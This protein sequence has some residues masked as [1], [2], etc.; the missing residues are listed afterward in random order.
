MKVV[1]IFGA[2]AVGKKT[3]A[4]YLCA[5]TGFRFYEHPIRYDVLKTLFWKNADAIDRRLKETV[6]QALC[7]QEER[8]IVIPLLWCF[9][10]PNGGKAV[11]YF[12]TFF[13][14]AG[15]EVC[16]A[17]LTAD[18]DTLLQRNR[19]KL[20]QEMQDDSIDLE[21]SKSDYLWH[22]DELRYTS[23]PGEMQGKR[24]F[25]LDTTAL[26]PEEAADRIRGAF[27]L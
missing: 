17:E 24:Y 22:T 1:I 12:E 7:E 23:L 26:S 27:H 4:T 3:V 25:W 16:F 11:R 10:H 14:N 19:D 8:G 18:D 6:L 2:Y 5:L 20:A 9:D 13:T 21:R 15:V